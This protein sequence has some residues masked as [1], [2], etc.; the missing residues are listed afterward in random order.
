MLVVQSR[1]RRTCSG[2][3]TI[4]VSSPYSTHDTRNYSRHE[5][6]FA[7]EG[8]NLFS[9]AKKTKTPIVERPSKSAKPQI[10]ILHVEDNRTV[11]RTVQ[12][13]LGAEGMHTDFC[14]SGATA[15]EMLKSNA[16]YDLIIVDNDLPGLSGLELVLR[17]QSIAHR[18]STPVI[19]LSGDDCESEAWRAG[20]KAFLRKP[21]GV[22]ELSSTVKRL[23]AQ[24]KDRG[25]MP[26]LIVSPP[27]VVCNL[28]LG[29][30][31]LKRAIGSDQ[32]CQAVAKRGGTRRP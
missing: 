3:S 16:P 17:I 19:M 23:L 13:T 20:V 24:R 11:A 4:R 28:V 32:C 31:S 8:A 30:A 22:N 9:G 14:L 12:D 27:G 26:H 10:A 18:R 29:T 2:S 7:N 15:L 5:Q 6:L 21:E 1:R 25:V